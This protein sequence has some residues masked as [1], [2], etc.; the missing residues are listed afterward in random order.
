MIWIS[1]DVTG[2]GARWLA[3]RLE[4]AVRERGSASI[5]LSGGH[6]PQPM[7]RELAVLPVPWHA[8]HVFFGDERGVPPEHHESNYGMARSALLDR[9]TAAAAHRMEAE[10]PDRDRA[11]SAYA[12]LLPDR[13]DVIVLGIGTDGHTASLFPGTDWSRPSLH[14]VLPTTAP[15]AP[16][17]RMTLAPEVLTGAR[18]VLMIATGT[19]KAGAVHD[20]LEGPIDLARC[21][22]QLVRSATWLLDRAAAAQLS[23]PPPADPGAP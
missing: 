2:D 17:A 13:F 15:A 3:V 12:A 6:S 23:A 19:A 20:A 21:P 14:R 1:D 10:R 18:N 11:A 22:A 8:V 9:V 5:A 7:H 4:E 16:Y